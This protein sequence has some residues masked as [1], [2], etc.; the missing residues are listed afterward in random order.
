MENK[1]FELE[2][3][4]CKNYYAIPN[5]LKKLLNALNGIEQVHLETTIFTE[6][7]LM[8]LCANYN[9]QDEI[10]KLLG[11][12]F[13]K[14]ED[15]FF[16]ET[17]LFY[18]KFLISK[19]APQ[20]EVHFGKTIVRRGSIIPDIS[21]WKGNQLIAIIECR[22]MIGSSRYNWEQKFNDRECQ[23]KEEFPKAKLYL[24]VMTGA[25]WFGFCDS[26]YYGNKYFLL[27]YQW[28]DNKNYSFKDMIAFPVEKLIYTIIKDYIR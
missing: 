2:K 4:M 9:S 27:S 15:D 26:E 19:V 11:K 20:L 8:R 3:E 13:R 7:I 16:C 10:I 5:E 28:P 22:T 6:A 18:F 14:D 12:R 21:I 24:L 17:I 25:H 23:L 1:V